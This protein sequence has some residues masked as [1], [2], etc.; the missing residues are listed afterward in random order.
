MRILCVGEVMLELSEHGH[1]L[2][3]M[4]IAGDTFNTAWHLKRLYG[5]SA[6]VGYFTCLGNDPFSARID[7][8]IAAS[9]INTEHICHT[10][11]RG[12]GL[13]AISLKNGERSFTYWRDQSAAKLLADDSIALKQALNWADSVYFSG[14]TLGILSPDA[15]IRFLNA[16]TEKRAQG[17]HIIFDPN[18]RPRLWE[19]HDIMRNVTMSA[20][21]ISDVVL[22]SFEDEATYFGDLSLEDCAQRYG[23]SQGREVII[24]NGGSD[25]LVCSEYAMQYFALEQVIPVDTTGAGDAFNAGWLAARAA[26]F[27]VE[28][29]VAKAHALALHVIARQGALV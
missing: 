26:G 29:A 1:P 16:L 6:E 3:S 4:G 13:Y 5:D 17:G 19:N 24:K 21:A 2:W 10:D 8:F 15:R 9:G 23:A 7:A 22:P 28:E 14:I 18:L 20:A 11:T 25:V 27:S 12:P